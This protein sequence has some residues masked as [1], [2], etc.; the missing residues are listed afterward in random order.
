V[1]IKDLFWGM[2]EGADCTITFGFVFH[3][4][5]VVSLLLFGVSVR[6]ITSVQLGLSRSWGVCI[7]LKVGV[8][9]N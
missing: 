2:L 6:M 3:E 5:C 4:M 7:S 9:D 1:K 8:I